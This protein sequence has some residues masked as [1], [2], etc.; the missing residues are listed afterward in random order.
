MWHG[1]VL[2]KE[3]FASLLAIDSAI[4]LETR[5]RACQRCGGPLCAGHYGRKPRG[6]LVAAAGESA[7]FTQ[8][9]SFCCSREGCRKRATPPSVRFLGRRVHLEGA[10]LIAC[11]LV[12]LLEQTQRAVCDAIGIAR[13]T[14]RRWK[15]WWSSA[16]VANALWVELRG[17][18]P[19]LGVAG[20]PGD[21]IEMFEGEAPTD[22]LLAAMRWL[23]P[24]STKT[25]D[26]SRFVRDGV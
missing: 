18:V 17:R 23:A 10:I 5:A 12:P 6:G 21:L 26:G 13:R 8:R 1:V 7:P 2:G 4:A 3:F 9:Y 19:G 22:K 14:V 20:L 15:S 16:F 25:A 24:L 11:A